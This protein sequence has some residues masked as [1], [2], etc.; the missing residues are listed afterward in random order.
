MVWK[1]Y[2]RHLLLLI[3]KTTHCM[4][5][6][7]VFKQKKLAHRFQMVHKGTP[8]ST[9]REDKERS[10]V[11][12]GGMVCKKR[13]NGNDKLFLVERKY[14]FGLVL[15]AERT[16][17]KASQTECE[18]RWNE[19]GKLIFHGSKW[20]AWLMHAARTAIENK[21]DASRE[22]SHPIFYRYTTEKR[23]MIIPTS[24]I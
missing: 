7:I 24:D 10:R 14:T 13:W 16:K 15:D 8:Q 3:S 20:V 11:G 6:V 12:T 4:N 2:Y 1:V 22:M 21:I 18:R 23:K 9:S 5:R 19:N 17:R